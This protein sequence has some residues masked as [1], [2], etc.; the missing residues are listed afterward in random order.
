MWCTMSFTQNV[1]LN[2]PWS[3]V[4]T[5][6]RSGRHQASMRARVPSVCHIFDINGLG[7]TLAVGFNLNCDIPTE[8]AA[9]QAPP[10]ADFGPRVLRRFHVKI[11]KPRDRARP[12]GPYC[13]ATAARGRG[14]HR[15]GRLDAAISMDSPHET[16][17]GRPRASRSKNAINNF[18]QRAADLSV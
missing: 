2:L 18:I 5:R 16:G 13:G 14:T 12:R 7:T 17:S 3:D 4:R 8:N 15:R 6:S 11:W 10:A 1:S 9:V